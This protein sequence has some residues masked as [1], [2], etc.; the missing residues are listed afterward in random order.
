MS[1]FFL[2]VLLSISVFIFAQY[3][4][5]IQAKKIY[6]KAFEIDLRSADDPYNINELNH[7]LLL[8][9]Q[10]NELVEKRCYREAIKSCQETIANYRRFHDF[11]DLG[12]KQVEQKRFKEALA[13]FS[14]ANEICFVDQLEAEIIKCQ[15][16]IPQQNNYE[17]ALEK[18]TLI[19][20]Q[21]K[22]EEAI[23]ILEPE[24]AK[25][26]R[27]DGSKLLAKLE[28]ICSAKDCYRLGLLAESNGIIGSAIKQYKEA[29]QILPELN[30]CQIRLAILSIKTNSP[31]EAISYL[32]GINNT[33]SSY[34]R[35]FAYTQLGNWQQA[36]REWRSISHVSV[37]RQRS[38]LKI[39]SDRDRLSHI[40]EI[41]KLVDSKQLE[42][43]KTVSLEFIQ[44]YGYEAAIE[45]NLK[46]HIQPN[47]EN[48][49]WDS[50]NW[51]T[52]VAKTE[53]IWLEKQDIK[54]LHNWAIASYY[55]YQIDSNKIID[56]ITAWSTAL[57]NI[58]IDG[59]LKNIPWL[60]SNS[61]DIRD[62]TQKLKYILE[63]AINAIK[64]RDVEEYLKLRDINRKDMV[65]LHLAQKSNCGLKTKTGLFIL[66]NCY[67]KLQNNLPEVKP[68][69]SFWSALYTN[70]GES[71]AACYEKD[72]SRAIQIKPKKSPS[73]EIEI[74]AY[75]FI[76]Y[77]EGC[78]YLENQ[79]WRKAMKILQVAKSE[80]IIKPDW[81]REIDRLCNIQRQ[82]IGEFTEHLEFS[83]SWYLLIG[84]KAS[85]SYYVEHQSMGIGMDA[86]DKKISFRQA[87]N[88]LKELQKIDPENLV[89]SNIISTLEINL[90]LEKINH[91]WQQSQYEEAVILAR[92][93][94][95]EKVR[96][97]VAEVCLE[98]VLEI[99][100]SGSLTY[101]AIQS[102]QKITKWAYELCP[103]EPL[104]Q[105]TYSQLQELGIHQ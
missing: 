68:N 24:Q 88:K 54:S 37:D 83:K 60:G 35:G 87:I 22:F 90:E 20:K 81:S 34:L 70:W 101:E 19:A 28:R 84:S 53:H 48:Q 40:L 86:D 25:F 94:H 92:R 105:T 38:A 31:M 56:L 67:Q 69:K 7:A 29:L 97:A 64:N 76:S 6:E 23:A 32:K 13:N 85:K 14:K 73:S 15:E 89:T 11:V 79:Y 66:P 43:A 72:V 45:H 3:K 1:L 41:E 103:H 65:L 63:N 96:F 99:L 17:Q 47:L 42:I 5:H 2:F 80:I 62:V 93:S 95:Y 16:D 50:R 21:G 104:F 98:I 77:H 36:N 12:K 10:C 71:V 82:Y 100:Q 59:S 55:Q 51:Q 102:L 9:K 33:Q 52:I 26:N 46:N 39:I 61:I 74:F 75:I 57:A 44:K 49:I 30:E 18:S 78:H 4:K 58:E 91:L 8:Y 27:D